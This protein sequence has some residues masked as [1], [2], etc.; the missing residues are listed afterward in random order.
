MKLTKRIFSLLMVL[1]LVFS[2]ALTAQAAPSGVS[3]ENGELIVFT[4]GSAYTDTDLFDD[5]KNVMP[6]DVRTEE[7]TI[8]NNSDDCDYIRVYLRAVPHDETGNPISPNVLAE[9]TAD[10]RRGERP[11]LDYMLDFLAQMHMTVSNGEVEIYN[12]SP[13]QLDGLAEN[14]FLGELRKGE[15][16]ELD[17]TLNVPIEM[18]NEYAGRIG[19]VDWMFTVEGFDDEPEPPKDDTVIT[20]HKVWIDDRIGRPE[21]VQVHLLKNGR[22]HDTVTLS[23]ENHWTYTWEGLERGN[24]WAVVEAPVPA[25]YVVTYV[26]FGNIVFIVNTEIPDCPPPTCPTEPSDPTCPTWPTCPTE[27]DPTCPSWPTCPTEP[28]PTC[29]SWPTWPTCPTDPSDPTTPSDPTDPT[30]PSDPTKPSDPT[31]PSTEPSEPTEPSTEPSEP[32]EPS[33]EPS[34]PTE[35]STEPTEP[36]TEPTDPTDPEPVKPVKLKVV[37]KWNDDG[38]KNRPDS[39]KVTLYNGQKAVETVVLGD[40]NN[41][42]YTWKNL[43]PDGEW[44]VLEVEIPKGY[45]PSYYSKNGVVTITNSVRL[46]QTGQLNWPIPVLS[47]LGILLMVSGVI[48]MRKKRKSKNA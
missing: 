15:S 17:V 46:I 43:D 7:I 5:F 4:P 2:M 1:S 38:K 16:L 31:E 18:G 44:R 37:K 11:E 22:I 14:V 41:W 9:L 12:E 26:P 21:S 32:T 39:V 33:T 8:Q 35:P 6:G 48:L 3:F 40:W 42:S 24:F 19:E 30:D 25:G 27:P 29:P 36:S 13:D 23:R 34:E 20:A 45:V 28:D 10:D 47:G